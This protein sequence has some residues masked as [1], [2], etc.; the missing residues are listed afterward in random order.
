MEKRH[1]KLIPML[2]LVSLFSQLGFGQG[3]TNPYQDGMKVKLSEDGLKY[4]RIIS[5]AQVQ[6]IYNDAVPENASN[7][8]LNLRRARVLMY[9]QLSKKFLILTHFGLNSLNSSSLSPTG[10]GSG[11][12]LFFH[13]V[14]VQYS[15][16]D[17]HAVGG[18]LHYFNGISRLN[19]QSTLNM[20]TMDNNRQSWSTLGLTDQFARHLGIFSKGTFG[21]LQYRLAINDVTTNNLD[22]RTPELNGGAVYGGKRLLGSAT[23]AFAFAG[24]LDYHFLDRE[25]NFLP[26]KVGS[27]L[28]AKK[29]LNVGAGF[30]VHPNGAVIAT[31]TIGGLKGENVALF[32]GDVF[33][34]MP[35]GTSG[36]AITAYATYQYNDY[37]K[38]YLFSA[39]GTGNMFYSHIGYVIPGNQAKTRFQPYASFSNNN[40]DVSPDARNLLGIGINAYFTGHQSKLTLDYKN[41][42]FGGTQS[43]V[44]TLQA[45]IFL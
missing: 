5:W 4:F 18:G 6:G 7:M 26:F 25:S 16:S 28:G 27:Y 8:S 2:L 38:D 42:K 35:I 3:V 14:W 11:S 12:Q 29:I 39:Y 45:M 10:T 21:K 36:G 24:Y 1:L 23:T 15:L 20:M 43:N 32:A 19:N 44:V 34:E 40:Y 22:L 37:G 9:S 41:Q 33:F 30:F 13:D 17:N 31:D